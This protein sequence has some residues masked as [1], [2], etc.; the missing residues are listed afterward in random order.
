MNGSHS[1]QMRDCDSC[2]TVTRCGQGPDA[3][4]CLEHTVDIRAVHSS[5]SQSSTRS[6]QVSP[7]LS[8]GVLQ[9]AL[10]LASDI[11][12]KKFEQKKHSLHH[13]PETPLKRNKAAAR[14]D[15]QCFLCEVESYARMTE[16]RKAWPEPRGGHCSVCRICSVLECR[17]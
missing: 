7:T 17:P 15:F 9:C 2:R 5:P 14:P 10:A 13:T 8:V 12:N 3:T 11:E 1:E 4:Q 16:L 6:V